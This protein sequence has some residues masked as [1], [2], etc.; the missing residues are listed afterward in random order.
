MTERGRREPWAM[1][2][3]GK[4]EEGPNLFMNGDELEVNTR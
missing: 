2:V 1:W 3:L 4:E